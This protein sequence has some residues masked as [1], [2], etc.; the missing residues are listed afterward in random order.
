MIFDD[1]TVNMSDSP[2]FNVLETAE[3]FASRHYDFL[4]VGGGTAGLAL[5]ARLSEET[6]FTIGILEAGQPHLNDSKILT[7]GLCGTLSGDPE[8]DWKFMT[9]PQVNLSTRFSVSLQ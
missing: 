4:V 6:S 8:Y 3:S 1:T 5:A 9:T 7:P 2:K